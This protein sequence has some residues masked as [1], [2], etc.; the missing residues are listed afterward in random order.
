M[1]EERV[2]SVEEVRRW[3]ETH[4]PT[5][6]V[7]DGML[8][9]TYRTGSWPR[10]LLV[11]QAIAFLGETAWHHPDLLLRYGS[12]EVRLMTHSA[13]GITDK[14]LELARRIE[15]VITWKPAEGSALSGPPEPVVK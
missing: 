1:A 12:V 15:E 2:Y 3:L 13:G 6:E 11:A 5:W 4:L 8:A 10:T 7:R 14:D 9:R